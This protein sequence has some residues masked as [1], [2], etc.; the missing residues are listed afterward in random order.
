MP[1]WKRGAI[2]L[3]TIAGSG[4]RHLDHYA[5]FMENNAR[6]LE[7]LRAPACAPDCTTPASILSY[8]Q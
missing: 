1:S 5:I 7:S 2:G 3:P 8:A 6:Y 4:L